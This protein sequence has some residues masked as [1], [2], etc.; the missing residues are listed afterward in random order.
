MTSLNTSTD[1]LDRLWN[2]VNERR[3]STTTVKVPVADLIA[4]LKDHAILAREVD[5]V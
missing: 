1:T 3:A 5:E 2:I 4:L